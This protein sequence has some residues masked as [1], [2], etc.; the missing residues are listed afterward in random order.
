M[1]GPRTNLPTSDMDSSG[2]W[3]R[4][5]RVVLCLFAPVVIHAQTWLHGPGHRSQPLTIPASG[6]P[7]FSPISP[8]QSGLWF[9]NTLPEQRHLTN[10]ILPNGSGVAAGDIDGDGWC[11]LFLC[12]LQSGSRLFRNL[13]Q[14]RFTDI[15]SAAGVNASNLDATGALLADIDGDRDLDL[16]VNSIGGG[17]AVWLNDGHGRFHVAPEI[18]NPDMGGTSSAMADGDGDGDL[19]L[20]IANYRV[21]TLMDFPGTRFNVQMVNGEPVVSTINGRPLADPEWTNRFRFK[22]SMAAG[23]RG[24]FSHE[25][26]GQA[27]A[28]FHNDGRGHFSRIPW[29]QGAFLDERGQPLTEPPF[30]WGL[31]VAFQDFNGD[32]APDLYL[33]NDFKSPDRLW[34][35]DGHG[36]FQAAPTLALRQICLSSMSIA[37]ADINRDGHAD[38]IAA[39]MLSRDH[40]RR[41]TQRNMA[42]EAM[43]GSTALAGRP[44]YPRNMLYL[45]LGDGDY[46]EIAQYSGLD[47]TEWTWAIAFLDVDLDGFED[48]LVPNGFERDN[49][50]VDVQNRIKQAKPAGRAASRDELALRRLFPRLTTHNL[51]FRN[52]GNLRFAETGALWGFNSTQVS[53]GMCLADLDNDGDLDVVINSLN[54]AAMLFRNESIAPRI[55]VQLKGKPPNTYGVGARITVAGGPVVQS[56]EMTCGGHYLSCDESK[57]VFAAGNPTNTLSIEVS[58][59]NGQHSRI[60]NALPNHLYEIGQ[61]AAFES[62]TKPSSPA[63]PPIFEDVTS[64]LGHVHQDDPFDD[65]ARQSLLPR[66]LSQLGPGVCWGDGNGD[67]WDDLIVGSGKGGRLAWYQNDTRG[68]LKPIAAFASMAPS[69]QDQTAILLWKPGEVLVGLSHYE[70][71]TTD[72][73]AVGILSIQSSELK[74]FI[75]AWESSIGPMALADYDGDG[76]LDLFVGGR[77][78]PGKYPIA[79]SSRLYR[80]RQGNMVMD[81]ANTALLRE[82]GLVSGAV[83]SDLDADGWPDLVLAC[84]WGPLHVFRNNHGQ[85]FEVTGALGLT[86]YIGWWNG[87]NTGDFDGDGRMDLVA[88]NWGQNTKYERYRAKPIRLYYGDF[89][90]DGNVE[91]IESCFESEKRDYAPIRML[92]SVA[93][94]MPFLSERFSTL[95]MWAETTLNQALGDRISQAQFHQA[96]WLESSLFLNRGSHFEP[97]ILPATAQFAPAFAVCVADYDGD[98]CEDVFLSQNFFSVEWETSRHDAGRGLWLHGNGQ[99]EFCA[100]RA[101][102]TGIRIYGEQRGAAVGDYD[103]DGRVDLVVAQNQAET[104]LFHNANGK[105]GLRI[106]LRGPPANPAAI[107]AAIR[108]KYGGRFGPAREVHAGS[109]YWSCDSPTQVLAAPEPPE[110]VWI[111]WPGGAATTTAVPSGARQMTISVDGTLSTR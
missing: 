95:Q 25:E 87:I 99:G 16:L 10:Q 64:M 14:W 53:Q 15:T 61:A 42:H 32:T 62:A 76:A 45:N 94:A 57:R 13:G 107:G 75:P 80:Q 19:D 17:T 55:A 105:P 79:A 4:F 63:Q 35:N 100:A 106:Q 66:S 101:Q 31:T 77:V 58:W 65:F 46:A 81:E 72:G 48:L 59:R 67:G 1:P 8:S 37:L 41:L 36:H 98:G 96:Q 54:D 69:P 93:K 18:L 29:T 33:C 56:Q 26:L 47:A 70:S 30:D 43:V 34:F 9:T 38:F 85:L 2:H 89:D 71:H 68:R 3:R 110:S 88:V 49:M 91:L 86:N 50:N 7:G 111:R 12:G 40:T 44:Q 78:I 74:G 104:R 102:E 73:S 103:A 20:Y 5:L 24:K 109:G 84:E 22:I 39:D 28:F 27:D 23:G 108:V 6:K 11:D 21:S 97:R 52:L 83:W 60:T 90:G 92:D 82:I 51:A